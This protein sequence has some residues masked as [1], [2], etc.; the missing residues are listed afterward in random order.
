MERL[1][2]GHPT[3]A[4]QLTVGHDHNH[5]SPCHRAN[6]LDAAWQRLPCQAAVTA[7][8]CAD[9]CDRRSA[10]P[11]LATFAPPARAAE[12]WTWRS[13]WSP[14][15]RAAST[16][17]SSSWRRMA[18]PPPSPVP[19]VIDAIQGGTDRG[20]RRRLCGIR[21]QL[22]SPH[23]AGLDGD[24]RQGLGAGL[25]RQACRRAAFLLGPH[26]DQFRRR[27]RRAVAGRERAATRP[28]G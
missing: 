12:T 19:A 28:A 27:S 14:T 24:P 16:T 6:F 18:T 8:S 10:V 20:D 2:R 21:Q 1:Y 23:G 9:T 11:A 15:F 26:R 13:C 25:R 4:R 17:A 3:A 7:S 5:L 22:R